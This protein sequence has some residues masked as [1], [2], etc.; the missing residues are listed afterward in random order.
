MG[1]KYI[2]IIKLW[3]IALGLILPE[4]TGAQEVASVTKD[5]FIL[6]PIGF[7][8]KEK[9]HT[10]LVLGKE[11]ESG[12]RGL[13]G[14]SHA[15]VL[16]WFDHNDTPKK[17]STLQVHP[18]GNP[19]NPLTGVFACRSP[20]RPNLIT[21]SLCRVV[22]V[23]VNVVEVDGIDAFSNTPILDI[24]PYIP[25]YDSAQASVPDWLVN[26]RESVSP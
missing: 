23:N 24:K 4:L 26:S 9:T 1:R 2:A 7:V 14:F 18:K 16:W 13:D 8:H 21:I 20:A 6:R 11:F 3:T 12:L 15:W 19:R 5:E 17:R 22:S 10:T 25:G